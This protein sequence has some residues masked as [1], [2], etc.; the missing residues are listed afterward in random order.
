MYNNSRVRVE[1]DVLQDSFKVGLCLSSLHT[2]DVD[3]H[4]IA[5]VG[6]R[7]G[8]RASQTRVAVCSIGDIASS[9]YFG[10]REHDDARRT[11]RIGTI[12]FLTRRDAHSQIPL[13]RTSPRVPVLILIPACLHHALQLRIG[14]V[15]RQ[16]REQCAVR[17]ERV[18][19]QS[20]VRRQSGLRG[21]CVR[22]SAATTKPREGRRRRRRRERGKG[23]PR[24]RGVVRVCLRMNLV[25]RVDGAR[26]TRET[27]PA[28]ASAA[29]LRVRC[30]VTQLALVM[31]RL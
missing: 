13:C 25:I 16:R 31:G 5:F 26:R 19:A 30:V 20:N 22:R 18:T 29:Q 14:L 15:P 9:G 23:H 27:H 2:E 28:A 1:V 8:R 24:A 4:S 17:R 6:A 10:G 11:Q 21:P 3:V 12:A 7:R